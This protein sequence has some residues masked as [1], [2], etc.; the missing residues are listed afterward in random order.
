MAGSADAALEY[1]L[2]AARLAAQR[3]SPE[4]AAQHLRQGL[5]VLELARP[6]DRRLRY[7]I[8]VELGQALLDA[9]RERAAHAALSDAIQVASELDDVDAMV[10]A[11]MRMS[12]ATLWQA[13][14]YGQL[15][16]RARRAG[17]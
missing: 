5:D 10:A 12:R 9:D 7:E 13:S 14:E 8:L 15:Q 6:G 1:S 11:A 3:V 17:S 4:G 2:L 16:S